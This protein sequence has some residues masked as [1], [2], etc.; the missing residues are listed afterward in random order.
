MVRP[1][2]GLSYNVCAWQ[3]RTLVGCYYVGRQ[4]NLH[5]KKKP[6]NKTKKINMVVILA[7]HSAKEQQVPKGGKQQ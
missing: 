6:Q 3:D 7:A 1:N 4:I 5:V 2:T